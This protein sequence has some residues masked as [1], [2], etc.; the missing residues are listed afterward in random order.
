MS[1]IDYEAKVR[2]YIE[3]IKTEARIDELKRADPWIESNVYIEARLHELKGK[4]DD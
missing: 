4:Q 3:K 1:D 2:E